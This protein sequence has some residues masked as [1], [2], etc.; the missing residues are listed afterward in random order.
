Y[1]C[2]N[3]LRNHLRDFHSKTHHCSSGRNEHVARASRA[4]KSIESGRLLRAEIAQVD[5]NL[6]QLADGLAKYVSYLWTH[7]L[8]QAI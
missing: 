3:C 7:I 4:F 1:Y 8:C 6:D 5:N 2:A